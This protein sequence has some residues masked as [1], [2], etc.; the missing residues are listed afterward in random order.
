MFELLTGEQQLTF[1]PSLIIKI[2]QALEDVQLK[3][4][5]ACLENKL[6]T[7]IAEHDMNFSVGERQLIC[8]A[9]AIL[10]SSSGK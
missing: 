6:Q 2:W 8:V 1:T 4:A 7:Q 5:I 3:P 10:K 9:R